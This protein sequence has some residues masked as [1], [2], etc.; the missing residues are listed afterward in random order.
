MECDFDITVRRY[1]PTLH[2]TLAGEL[3]LDTRS[4]L[5]DVQAAFT[6][7]V[8]VLA[9]DMQRLTFMDVTGMHRLLDL[10][11]RAGERGIAFLAY[12]WRPQ[13]RRL[14]D[15]V[16]SLYPPERTGKPRTGPTSLLSR[17][18]RNAVTSHRATGAETV[19]AAVSRRRL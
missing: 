17:T 6:E 4:A 14:L 5:D 7:G 9:C 3:D 1:G 8:A 16:D 19:H 13:P 2:V 10:A 11:R 18:L 15:L 12:N